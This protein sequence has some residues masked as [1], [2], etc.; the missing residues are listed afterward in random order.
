[1]G[2][3]CSSPSAFPSA[4][5][6]PTHPSKGYNISEV[7]NTHDSVYDMTWQADTT[8][9]R[10]IFT[11]IHLLRFAPLTYCLY[12]IT[13]MI[14]FSL[15]GSS[16]ACRF[17]R[18]SCDSS[19]VLPVVRRAY[20][21]L[22]LFQ[23]YFKAEKV[24]TIQKILKILDRISRLGKVCSTVCSRHPPSFLQAQQRSQRYRMFSLW[25]RLQVCLRTFLDALMSDL[26]TDWR[27]VHRVTKFDVE[28]STFMP[29]F[30]D[31]VRD[32][33]S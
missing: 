23:L 28:S 14:T 1:M 5:L 21:H 30:L 13:F 9:F 22:G 4:F 29:S 12:N 10:D 24:P 2:K 32:P 3:A 11:S 33:L 31:P 17:G 7:W 20:V 26:P 19:G 25:L 6:F 15:Y 27:A 8:L 16:G 18:T